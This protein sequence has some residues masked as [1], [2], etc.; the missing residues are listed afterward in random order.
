[1]HGAGSGNG[2]FD[3]G[4]QKADADALPRGIIQHMPAM[5]AGD[6]RA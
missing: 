2:L 1:M 6:Q 4:D 3:A 5:R